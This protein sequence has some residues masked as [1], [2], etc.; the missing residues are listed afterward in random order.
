MRRLLLQE[1]KD[2]C[3]FS[4]FP[5]FHLLFKIGLIFLV[6]N[7]GSFCLSVLQDLLHLHF[8]LLPPQPECFIDRYFY[9]MYL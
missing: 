4:S 3:V 7:F 5:S 6:R 2:S 9:R 1:K 8:A